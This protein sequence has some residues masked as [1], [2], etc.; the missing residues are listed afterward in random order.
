MGKKKDIYFFSIE[1]ED[2]RQAIA[3]QNLIFTNDYMGMVMNGS[4]KKVDFLKEGEIYH[5]AEPRLLLVLNG[6][7]DVD[8]NLESYQ[9]TKGSAVLTSSDAIMES[10][11]WSED[12]KVIGIVL[13]EDI[14]VHET[15]ALPLHPTEF[16]RLLRMAYLVWD[17]ANQPPF[18]KE[19][20]GH[21]LNAMIA[22]VQH[23]HDTTEQTDKEHRPTRQELLFQNFKKLVSNHCE[24]ERSIPFYAEQLW[25]SPHHLSAVISK[26]S[27]HSVMYWINR[28]VILKAKMLLK[29]SGMMSYEIADQLNFPSAS[30]FSKYFK[31]ET[32]M[33]PGEYQNKS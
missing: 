24:K 30:A 17:L 3:L 11:Y 4:P 32:G 5:I 25:I 33:T 22:D 7:A 29:T 12:M 10:R 26:V 8:I 16:D 31:R 20:I 27:G 18:R 14:H 9:L 21:L 2:I 6:E 28:A 19:T 23:I 1:S 15:I 13:S